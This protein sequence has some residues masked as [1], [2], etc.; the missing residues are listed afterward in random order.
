MI[1]SG[2]ASRIAFNRIDAETIQT[3]R[4]GK[5][6]LLSVMPAIK[7][8]DACQRHAAEALGDHT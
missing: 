7:P 2:I 3:L 6:F 5:T 4:T 1:E 8:H